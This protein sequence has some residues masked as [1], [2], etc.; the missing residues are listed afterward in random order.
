PNGAAIFAAVDMDTTAS[1]LPVVA[2][3]EAGFTIGAAG[4]RVGLYAD[5]ATLANT[6][7]IPWLAGAMGWNG[8]K[9]Y[10]ATGLWAMKQGPTLNHGGRWEGYDGPDLGFPY[11]PNLIARDIGAWLPTSAPTASIANPSWS[12]IQTRL[13]ALG[14]QPPLKVDGTAGALTRQAIMKA[15]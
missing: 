9:A 14:A 11:D 1:V 5:G 8:S 6:P 3:Y 4:Y 2:A 12:D 10:D 13:N 7:G 15:L